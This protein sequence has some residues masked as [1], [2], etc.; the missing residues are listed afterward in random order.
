M[1]ESNFEVVKATNFKKVDPSE[2]SNEYE[3][4]NLS[5]DATKTA[6]ELAMVKA[7]KE[8]KE[9]KTPTLVVRP[10]SF[11]NF[12][13]FLN[14]TPFRTNTISTTNLMKGLIAIKKYKPTKSTGQKSCRI[15]NINFHFRAICKPKSQISEQTAKQVEKS[16]NFPHHLS[17]QHHNHGADQLSNPESGQMSHFNTL[18]DHL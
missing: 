16:T 18:A 17:K 12:Y 2:P 11:G 8:V 15:I 1:N 5:K 10:R 13:P 7:L 14:R 9:P 6:V 3:K 4:T